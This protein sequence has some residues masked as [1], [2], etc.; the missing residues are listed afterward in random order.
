ML[1]P[2]ISTTPNSPTVWAKPRMAAVM[3]PGRAR[4]RMTLKKL[5]Q[6]PARKVAATSSGR[7]PMAENAFCSGWTTNGI[8]YSTDPIT[9]PAKLNVRVPRP[10]DWVSWPTKPWGPSASNR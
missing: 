3:K 6:G 10:R 5:S 1:P 7:V 2:I 8:E 4:G 9:R